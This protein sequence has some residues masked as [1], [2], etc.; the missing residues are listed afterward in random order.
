MIGIQNVEYV[1]FADKAGREGWKILFF[2]APTV[3]LRCGK[4]PRCG[5]NSSF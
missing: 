5:E 1:I 2:V 4:S 3:N